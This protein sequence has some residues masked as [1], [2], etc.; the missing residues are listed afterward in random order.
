MFIIE[1]YQTQK[2]EIIS[3]QSWPCILFLFYL[4]A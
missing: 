3:F 1:P 4:Q 2:E